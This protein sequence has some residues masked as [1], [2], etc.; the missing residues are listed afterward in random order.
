MPDSV[1]TNRYEGLCA[2]CGR[3]VA[4]EA[5]VRLQSLWGYPVIYHPA[6]VPETDARGVTSDASAMRPNQ[7][8]EQCQVCGVVVRA[9]LGVLVRSRF[10]GW[11]VYHPEHLLEPAPPR[12]GRHQGWHQRLLMAVDIETT[13]NRYNIDR[14]IGAAVLTSDGTTRSWLIDP[15]PG[16]LSIAPYK[17]HGIT[18]R[19]ARTHGTPAALA[20]N[21]IATVMVRHLLAKEPLVVWHAPFV[22]TTLEAELLRH[23]LAALSDRAPKG[24]FPICDPLVLDRHADQFRPGGRALQSV[25][26]WYGIPHCCPSRAASDAEASLVLAQVI[27]S[28]FPSIGRLSRPALHREQVRW[29]EQYVRE[30]EARHPD[31]DRDTAWPLGSVEPLPWADHDSV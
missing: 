31:K 2:R 13:G 6:H 11:R 10:D 1:R 20:L 23:G 26:K 21:D 5:G 29:H 30:A 24:L 27:G 3:T 12:R 9:G 8:E 22:L 19:H 14:V 15:G 28:C 16:P 4:A 25:T 18:L 7:R 17:G